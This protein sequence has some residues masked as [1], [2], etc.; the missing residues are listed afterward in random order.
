MAAAR[1]SV[2]VS[3]RERRFTTLILAMSNESTLVIE[4]YGWRCRAGRVSVKWRPFIM[5]VY[6]AR[7]CIIAHN[8]MQKTRGQGGILYINTAARTV[9]VRF[10]CGV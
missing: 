3:D 2:A 9:I 10:L 7:A 8:R 5:A 6:R 1:K 4:I